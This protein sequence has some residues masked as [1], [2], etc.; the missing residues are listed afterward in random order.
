MNGGGEGVSTNLTESKAVF[1]EIHRVLRSPGILYAATGGKA[2]GLTIKDWVRKVRS[3]IH[4]EDKEIE[5]GRAFSLETGVSQLAQ[6]FAKIMIHK[7]QDALEITE[8]EPL[9]DY[10]QSTIFM[11]LNA[12]DLAEFRRIVREEI[13]LYGAVVIA[14]S[15]G[16]LEARKPNGKRQS[17]SCLAGASGFGVCDFSAGRT[18]SY[19]T[20]T[21]QVT[22][23]EVAVLAAARNPATRTE[24]QKSA[25]LLDR[26][27][28][29][30]T[31]LKPLIEA[32]FLEMTIPDK[33]RSSKQ[34]YRLTAKG[35]AV[36]KDEG[37]RGD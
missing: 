24:L 29:V 32:G 35:Q 30:N 12:R 18:T 28:F 25:R 26:E 6:W 9:V 7:Y 36:V 4:E 8:V 10:V 17:C 2:E 31:C 27:H 21:R 22:P 13:D 14:K 20:S 15:A 16:I 34:K 11:H 3:K 5:L 23:Q 19:P 37:G 1:T 33:P